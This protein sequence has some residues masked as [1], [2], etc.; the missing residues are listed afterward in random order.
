MKLMLQQVSGGELAYGGITDAA[1]LSANLA[2]NC[3]PEEFTEMDIWSYGIFL[4]QHRAKIAE[5][6]KNYYQSLS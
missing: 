4:E 3:I 6:I 1:D 5:Y 2:E